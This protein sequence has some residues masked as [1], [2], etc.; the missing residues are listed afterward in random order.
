MQNEWA[1]IYADTKTE[2][3]ILIPIIHNR[4]DI[5]SIQ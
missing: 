2:F 5:R 1:G 4:L 3:F